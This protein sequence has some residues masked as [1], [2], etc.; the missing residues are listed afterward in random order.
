MKWD[1]CT[2]S[3][4]LK[5]RYAD[6]STDLKTHVSTITTYTIIHLP[7]PTLAIYGSF[8]VFKYNIMYEHN[9]RQPLKLHMFFKMKC[10]LYK[11]KNVL[12]VNFFIVWLAERDR[13][14]I[15]GWFTFVEVT[16]RCAC[17]SIVNWTCKN[18]FDLFF[19]HPGDH[20]PG[21][22]IARLRTHHVDHC[23]AH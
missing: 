17:C 23:Y 15:I 20:V 21:T 6:S 3:S 1:S 5:L 13:C 12:G 4:I 7:W 18:M 22:L 8:R 19:I 10:L 16:S 14:E 11:K 9:R 2:P